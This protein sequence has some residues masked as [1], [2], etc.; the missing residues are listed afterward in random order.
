MIKLR[1]GYNEKYPFDAAAYL[2][3]KN[4]LKDIR[5]TFYWQ[6]GLTLTALIILITTVFILGVQS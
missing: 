1:T 3:Y 4:K 2:R 6:F 5:K